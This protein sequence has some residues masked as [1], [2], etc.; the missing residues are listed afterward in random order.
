MEV[1]KILSVQPLDDKKLLV[2]FANGIEKV[3]A[4]KPLVEK[5]ELFKALENEV[6]FKQVKV[7]AGGYGISWNDNVDLSEDELWVNA[8]EVIKT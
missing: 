5:F 6:F 3:Y 1:P 2:K 7:D 4:C 8:V